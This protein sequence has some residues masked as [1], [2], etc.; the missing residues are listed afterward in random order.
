MFIIHVVAMVV[1]F[2]MVTVVVM[3]FV[4][5]VRKAIVVVLGCDGG[6]HCFSGGFGCAGRGANVHSDGGGGN[7]DIKFVMMTMIGV[8]EIVMMLMILMVLVVVASF[9]VSTGGDG[10]LMTIIL[11]NG[12][13]MPILVLMVKI[14][15]VML[16]AVVMA[17]LVIT[18]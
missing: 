14:M 3:V 17:V 7:I 16:A 8:M 12:V 1:V 18:W 15:T 10:E 5:E 9:N 4:L 2:I 13:L 11:A 6:S